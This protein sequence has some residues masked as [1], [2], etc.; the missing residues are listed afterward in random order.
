MPEENN[1]IGVLCWS[2]PRHPNV[3][4]CKL[5]VENQ[6]ELAMANKED[7]TKRKSNCTC[8]EN[9]SVGRFRHQTNP[10]PYN[11]TNR[12]R[13][14]PTAKTNQHLNNNRKLNS[15]L[16][17]RSTESLK[18]NAST[19]GKLDIANRSAE[20]DNATRPTAASSLTRSRECSPR[21]WQTKIKY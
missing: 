9:I 18:K 11:L 14:Q 2:R 8:C 10:Q 5:P 13:L 15:R 3:S 1:K 21:Y 4:F 16:T 7:A 6:R 20:A 17:N 12:R 19:A